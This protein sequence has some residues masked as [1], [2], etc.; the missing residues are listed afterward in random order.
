MEIK[1]LLGKRGAKNEQTNF[2]LTE[3]LQLV[4]WDYVTLSCILDC[5]KN[6]TFLRS[7]LHF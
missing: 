2:G 7:N 6:H 1:S 5:I 4:N 3:V